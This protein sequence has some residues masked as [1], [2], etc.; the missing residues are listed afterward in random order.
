ME[1]LLDSSLCDSM[2][3]TLNHTTVF[4]YD[5]ELKTKHSQ[6]CAVLD[7][8]RHA[9][10]WINTHQQTPQGQY[11]PTGLM[12]FMM[13]ASLVKDSIENLRKA[14]GVSSVLFDAGRPESHQF[15][16]DVC[17]RE[18]LNIPYDSC[19]TD[20]GFFQYFRSLVFAHSGKI[21]MSQGVLRKN[22]VQ[23]SPFIVESG[24]RNYANEPD[25]YVGVMIYST[26]KDRDWKILRVRFSV[27]KAYLKSR[28]ESLG[29]VLEKIEKKIRSA[30][31]EWINVKV[32]LGQSPLEQ[33][34]F[35]R[36]EFAR[37]GE[38][39]MEYEVRRL[40]DFLEAPCTITTNFDRVVEY[41]KDIENAVPRLVE[42]FSAL[43]YS[44]FIEIVDHFADHEVD[45]SLNL[46]YTLQKIFEY[47]NDPERREW[48]TCDID[49]VAQ[50][51]VGKW[52]KINQNI[53]SVSELKMLITI[54]CYFEYSRFQKIERSDSKQKKIGERAASCFGIDPT[55]AEVE[56]DV[57]AD[58]ADK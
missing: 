29:L 46:N 17:A 32:D 35:I 45:E 3:N 57:Q 9:T 40:I 24:L 56:E 48:A 7:R 5:E 14:F 10:A 8:L 27:L 37:R 43:N 50:D 36:G 30:H 41:R 49:M 33:L 38:Y 39:C 22:E 25:D 31:K 21:T 28:Y 12:T 16:S 52:V 19:P 4:S 53:M 18:P 2:Y 55:V 51:F 6:V 47:L 11:A 58:N 1:P 23:Y 54:A 20:D 44:D 15:F 13:F 26:E 34:K 42:C